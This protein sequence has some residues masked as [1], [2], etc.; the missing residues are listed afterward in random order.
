MEKQPIGAKC[1]IYPMPTTLV[2]TNVRGKPTY[3]TIAACNMLCSKPPTVFVSLVK[4]RYTTIG[5]K[6]NNTFSINVPSADMVK[7]TDYCGIMSGHKVDK[8]KLF[9]SFYGKLGTAPM[10]AECSINMECKVVQTLEYGRDDIFIGEVMEAYAEDKYLTNGLPDMKKIAPIAFSFN[11][12]NYWNI[13]EHLG[14]AYSI[15]REF[16]PDK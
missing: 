7:V 4:S 10:I 11:D 14:K 9:T 12:D 8:S 13:G 6:E 2:G 1:F 3:L 5:I 15:G 16:K